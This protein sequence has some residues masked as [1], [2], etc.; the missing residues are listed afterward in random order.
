MS[1]GKQKAKSV[2]LCVR[3]Q[4]GSVFFFCCAVNWNN[5]HQGN[6]QVCILVGKKIRQK[7]LHVHVSFYCIQLK[8]VD[9]LIDRSFQA[10]DAQHTPDVDAWMRKGRCLLGF[11]PHNG[12]Q[13]WQRSRFFGRLLLAWDGQCWEWSNRDGTTQKK[14]TIYGFVLLH[15]HFV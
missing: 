3:I 4:H 15:L 8:D 5:K 11:R 12:N 13:K 14:K 9:S 6:L 1:T 7:W 10:E 2:C